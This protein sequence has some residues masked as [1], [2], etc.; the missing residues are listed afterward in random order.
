MTSVQ[1]RVRV[2]VCLVV[3]LASLTGGQA[4][5]QSRGDTIFFAAAAGSGVALPDDP[6]FAA[7][8]R[9]GAVWEVFFGWGLTDNWAIGID[10]ATWQ[11]SWLGLPFHYH[12]GFHP[13]VEWTPWGGDGVVL[14]LSSG[15]STTDGVKPPAST[16]Q[17]VGVSPRL[18][19]RFAVDGGLTLTAAVGAH[20]HLYLGGTSATVPFLVGELRMYGDFGGR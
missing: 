7:G 2:A 10:F 9:P 16:R 11:T 6:Q 17:G 15:L 5:A 12:N 1:G 3:S 20:Q 19:Y 4:Q 8:A 14:A 18:G 13:R